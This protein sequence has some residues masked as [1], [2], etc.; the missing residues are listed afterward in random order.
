MRRVLTAIALLMTAL[1]LSTPCHPAA[2]DYP[3][4][5]DYITDEE[6]VILYSSWYD[7]IHWVCEVLEEETSCVMAVLVVNNTDGED[8]AMWS[9]EVFNQNGIGQEG[10]D[11]GVLIVVAVGDGT[12][13]I[14]VGLGLEYVLNDAKVA[15]I[16]RE[17]LEPYL[18]VGDY[19]QGIY[20]LALWLGAEIEESYE[21]SEPKRYPIEWI[22]LEW[23]QLF[24]AC[25]VSLLV[26]FLTGGRILVWIGPWLSDLGG[27]KAGGGG[28]G[29]RFRR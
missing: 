6:G 9:T 27:G 18:A 16:A 22:P 13:F 5:R 28:A 29:G 17:E 7:S 20:Y 14:A 21:E 10:K 25:G 1:L 3:V 4:L 11:N 8:I 26:I 12:Y 24:M 15:R 23:P 19:G 2:A